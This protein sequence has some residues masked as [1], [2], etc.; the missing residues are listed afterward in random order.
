MIVSEA[1]PSGGTATKSAVRPSE[2]DKQYKSRSSP[3]NW[4][5][6]PNRNKVF[7]IGGSILTALTNGAVADGREYLP[8][9]T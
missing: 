9:E 6:K 5:G 2:T 3:A 7:I 4:R 1:E 8:R